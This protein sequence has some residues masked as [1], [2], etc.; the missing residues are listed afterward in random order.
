M[1]DR[2]TSGAKTG[3]TVADRARENRLFVRLLLARKQPEFAA[4]LGAAVA[5]MTLAED[6]AA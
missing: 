3:L 6:G 2:L 1:T 4:A 5:E